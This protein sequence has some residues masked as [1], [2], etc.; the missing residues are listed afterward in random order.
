MFPILSTDFTSNWNTSNS[1]L[2]G[3]K[4]I[5]D[6]SLVSVQEESVFHRYLYPVTS[7]SGSSPHQCNSCL[8]V[9]MVVNACGNVSTIIEVSI[10]GSLNS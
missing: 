2:M 4:N 9:V 5:A 7:P 1:F 6:S 3:T 8:L 10:S